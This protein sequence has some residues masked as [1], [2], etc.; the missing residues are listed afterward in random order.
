MLA[1]PLHGEHRLPVYTTCLFC[2][3]DLG[4][5]EAIE[6]FSVAKVGARQKA[7]LAKAGHAAE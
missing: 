3:S 1:T 6:H 4:R 2:S 5:N 7:A